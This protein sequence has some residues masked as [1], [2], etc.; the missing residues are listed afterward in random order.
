MTLM[1]RPLSVLDRPL[2]RNQRSLFTWP[3]LWNDDI[4]DLDVRVEEFER[5]GYFV[6]RAE[7]P[8][9]NPDEDIDITVTDRTL[10]LMIH[11]EHSEQRALLKHYR[12][13]FQYGSFTRLLALP[14]TASDKDIKA[15]YK[16]GILE[17]HVKL[18]G[19]TSSEK[20]IPITKM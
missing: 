4:V 17:I 12:T 11:R 10:R 9:I 15:T 14:Q 16:D 8:G 2:W 6:I 13:E 5:D 20:K 1:T 7:V 19:H 3:E 18:N